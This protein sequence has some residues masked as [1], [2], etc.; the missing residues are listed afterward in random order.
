MSVSGIGQQDDVTFIWSAA[1]RNRNWSALEDTLT[2]PGHRL[3]IDK[4]GVWSLGC[5]QH[6]N[7]NLPREIRGLCAKV[8]RERQGI[9]LF[10]SATNDSKPRAS[11][12]VS[13]QKRR[14]RPAHDHV[15]CSLR[16]A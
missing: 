5:K 15:S 12:R 13:L 9:S 8:P 16:P 1:T 2:E 6:E 4:C 10:G 11:S 3:R 14:L 7:Q